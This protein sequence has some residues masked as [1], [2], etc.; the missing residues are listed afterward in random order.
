MSSQQILIGDYKFF[1]FKLVENTTVRFKVATMNGKDADNSDL[2]KATAIIKEM[3]KWESLV[4][5]TSFLLSDIGFSFATQPVLTN[6]KKTG[7]DLYEIKSELT[8]GRL[9]FRLNIRA[10]ERRIR[11]AL[12]IQPVLAIDEITRQLSNIPKLSI[13]KTTIKIIREELI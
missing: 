2:E 13:L 11:E 5:G 6:Y 12:N 1:D 8:F 3:G 9:D 4:D 7:I 10:E